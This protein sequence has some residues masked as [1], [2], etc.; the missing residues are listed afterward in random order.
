LRVTVKTDII[1]KW[2]DSGYVNYLSIP[3]LKWC[4]VK[5]KGPQFILSLCL[6]YCAGIK[7]WAIVVLLCRYKRVG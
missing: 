1:K 5:S 6:C 7:E 3:F 4:T 2:L